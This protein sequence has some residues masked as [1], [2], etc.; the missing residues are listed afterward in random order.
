MH[1]GWIFPDIDFFI[2]FLLILECRYPWKKRD[3]AQCYIYQLIFI[4]NHLEIV[5]SVVILWLKLKDQPRE[6]IIDVKVLALIEFVCFH[7]F[8]QEVAPD[9]IAIPLKKVLIGL[10][11]VLKVQS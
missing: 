4:I 1:F 8:I 6:L 3:Q 5:Y 11:E 9:I 10:V 2:F 7:E